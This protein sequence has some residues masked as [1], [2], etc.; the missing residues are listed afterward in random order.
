MSRIEEITGEYALRQQRWL[1]TIDEPEAIF[2]YLVELQTRIKELYDLRSDHNRSLNEVD[3][4]Y[5]LKILAMLENYAQHRF[6]ALKNETAKI[7]HRFQGLCK[8][9]IDRDLY[10]KIYNASKLTIGEA[11]SKLDRELH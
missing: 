8:I 2:T 5:K 6:D 10:R 4:N 7:Q 3:V 11:K 9:Y 1:Q